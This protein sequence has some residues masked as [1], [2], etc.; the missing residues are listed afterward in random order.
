M[1]DANEARVMEIIQATLGVRDREIRPED[2]F[3]DDLQVDSLNLVELVYAFEGAFDI[4]I[5]QEEA[6]AIVTV[7]DAIRCVKGKL[8]N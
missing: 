4:S 7:A 6:E 2:S 5:A 1:A 3:V 8:P